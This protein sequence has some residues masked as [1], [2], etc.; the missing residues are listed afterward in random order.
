MLS[1]L[2]ACDILSV[3]LQL[4]GSF[5]TLGSLLQLQRILSRLHRLHRLQLLPLGFQ[6]PLKKKNKTCHNLWKLCYCRLI[7]INTSEYIKYLSVHNHLLLKSNC[8]VK[9]LQTPKYVVISKNLDCW[10]NIFCW[11]TLML[12]VPLEV[13]NCCCICSI[14]LCYTHTLGF[15]T[16]SGDLSSTYLHME[17]ESE[18]ERE[19]K[20]VSD[21]WEGKTYNMLTL[22]TTKYYII[23]LAVLSPPIIYKIY[24]TVLLICTYGTRAVW[25]I[26]MHA[27]TI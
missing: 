5:Q 19:R 22:L 23:N 7:S 4:L 2:L 13:D 25:H 24:K 26:F 3:L 18:K 14:L 16:N 1:Y 8:F 11:D 17:I 10:A 12:K 6:L 21:R 9:S 15:A 20:W 27:E